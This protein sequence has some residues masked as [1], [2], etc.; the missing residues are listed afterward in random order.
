MVRH[1]AVWQARGW[2]LLVVA[3]LLF[4]AL[5]GLRVTRRLVVGVHREQ[6]VGA[7]N[8]QAVSQSPIRLPSVSVK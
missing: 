3:S 4:A 6:P 2:R 8:A 5:S 1:G 7:R